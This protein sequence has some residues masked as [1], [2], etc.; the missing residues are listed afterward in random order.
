[1]AMSS[2]HPTT[3][4]PRC[5]I[6]TRVSDEKQSGASSQ[7]TTTRRIVR[8]N[9]LDVVAEVEDDGLSGDD[10]AR[11]GLG[12]VMTTLEREYRL[13]RPVRWIVIDQSDRLS[14]A[15][16][17]DT[18]EV[19]ARMRRLGV[20]KVATPA[21]TF[22]LYSAL[23]RTLLQIEADHKNN[24]YLK[25]LGRRTLNGMLDAARAGFWTGQKPPFGYK[26]VY[27]LGD[28]GGRK[29]KSGRLVID[30]DTAPIVRE[31][32]DRAAAGESTRDLT[33]WLSARTGRR[34]SRRGVQKLLQKEIYTGTRVFGGRHRGKHA[35]LQDGVAVEIQTPDDDPDDETFDDEDQEAKDE[36]VTVVR[37]TV[38]PAIID[39][40]TFQRVQARLANPP[41]RS[42]KKNVPLNPLSGLC[43]CGPCGSAM[44]SSRQRTYPYLVCH[45]RSEE[46]RAAC[47]TSVYA[48]GDVVLERV[49]ATLAE[50]LLDGDTVA[51]LV[52]L[53]GEAEDEARKAHEAALASAGKALEACDARLARA[54][55]RLAECEDDLLED[56]K[57]TVRDLKEKRAACEADLARI[58][59]EPPCGE[60]GDAET[61]THWLESCKAM[62][63]GTVGS[64]ADQNAVL[65]EL[66]V[67]VRVFPP[68]HP[69]KGKTVGR[70]EVGLPEWLNRVV[71]TTGGSGPGRSP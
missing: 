20:R 46:G 62:C 55:L 7:L 15:D 23:D 33:R 41:T 4:R 26:V 45:R 65:R 14:R 63:G 34:W 24:P 57:A 58:R 44:N 22:D 35:R 50:R 67:E 1:M 52:E 42:R 48:R 31:L 53:A 64:P 61:L 47:P 56:F 40:E 17:L 9:N 43:R 32:F 27:T 29:R 39:V 6:Y 60:V 36:P 28:H 10:M 11:A 70:L 54:R 5:I 3:S 18:S 25:D 21:R 13:R 51:R 66:V 49:L 12:E 2:D 69:G 38:C 68:E 37:L 16:S 30:E 19:L 71:A 8:D 59:A